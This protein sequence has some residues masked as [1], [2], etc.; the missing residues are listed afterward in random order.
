MP[1]EALPD[2]SSRQLRAVVAVAQYRSFIAA[3]TA[4]KLSQPA[5]TRIIKLAVETLQ[6]PFELRSFSGPPGSPTQGHRISRA[7]TATI[8]LKVPAT[9]LSSAGLDKL[10]L[11]LY[12]IKPG[13]PLAQVNTEVLQKL[14]LEGRLDR[15]VEFSGSDLARQILQ[16]GRPLRTPQ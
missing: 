14:K 3:A 10:Q 5:I 12:S 7:K 2:I 11:R 1:Q 6:D 4:L 8:T 15:R 13:A 9:N 16:K